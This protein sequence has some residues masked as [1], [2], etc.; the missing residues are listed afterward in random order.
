M[1]VVCRALVRL[2]FMIALKLIALLPL[3]LIGYPIGFIWEGIS[4][5]VFAGIN[6]VRKMGDRFAGDL[7]KRK[8]NGG[9]QPR[10]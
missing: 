4:V 2:F 7:A 10:A 1:P 6:S 8:A 9:S 3:I 5:G